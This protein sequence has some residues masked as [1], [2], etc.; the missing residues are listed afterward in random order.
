MLQNP[1]IHQTAELS[2]NRNRNEPPIPPCHLDLLSASRWSPGRLTDPPL[3]LTIRAPTQ[4]GG[5]LFGFLMGQNR[6][7]E[8]PGSPPAAPRPRLRREWPVFSIM[9]RFRHR[10]R[11]PPMRRPSRASFPGG[12]LLAFLCLFSPFAGCDRSHRDSSPDPMRQIA[13]FRAEGT[14]DQALALASQRLSHLRTQADRPAYEII[15]ADVLCRTLTDI[16]ALPLQARALMAHADSLDLPSLAELH[17]HDLPRT[18]HLLRLQARLRQQHL[19][20]DSPELA[21]SYDHLADVMWR[22]SALSSADSLYQFSLAIRRRALGADHPLV[23]STMTKLGKLCVELGDYARSEEYFRE[24]LRSRR[25]IWGD[26]SAPVAQSLTNLAG[27]LILSGDYWSAEPIA[28][29]SLAIYRGLSSAWNTESVT[30]LSNLATIYAARGDFHLA[31]PLYRQALEHDRESL[32]DLDPMLAISINNLAT[33]LQ[34]ERKYTEAEALYQEALDLRMATFGDADA[35]VA[36]SMN[37]LAN[38]LHDLGRFDQAESLY[39]RALA[40]RLDLLGPDHPDVATT[41]NNIALLDMDRGDT[42]SAEAR[43][44]E[45]IRARRLVLGRQHPRVARS[46]LQLGLLYLSE[47]RNAEAESVLAAAATAFDAARARVTPDLAR[48]TFESSPYPALAVARLRLQ[49]PVEAWAA[50]ELALGRSL[51]EILRASEQRGLSPRQSAAEDSLLKA[52]VDAEGRLEAVR[53]RTRLDRSP[54]TAHL[55][56]M[57]YGELL[58][59][60]QRWLDLEQ[61]LSRE[62][63]LTEGRR[64]D[65]DRIQNSLEPGSAV[66]GWID[67]TLGG[68]RCTQT[69][70]WGYVIRKDRGATW[71]KL[72]TSLG[73]HLSSESQPTAIAQAY[74]DVLADPAQEPYIGIP[75]ETL[76]RQV[77]TQRFAPFSALL[78]GISQLIVIPSA[79]MLGVPVEALPARPGVNLGDLVAV[80]YAPSATIYAW[81]LEKARATDGDRDKTMLLVADP[82]FDEQQRKEIETLAASPG[83]DS[84]DTM[85][86]NLAYAGPHITADRATAGSLRRLPYTRLEA[87]GIAALPGVSADLLL[88]T[89][90]REDTLRTIARD[91]RISR[92]RYVHI[93]THTIPND[94]NPE[95]SYLVLSQ[96]DLPEPIT[97]VIR[98]TPVFDGRLTARE[99]LAEWELSADLVTLS[100]CETA[101]GRSVGGEGYIGLASAFLQAGARS[102]VVSLWRVNDRSASLLMERF[103][104]NLMGASGLSGSEPMTKS[105]ALQEAKAW[106]RHYEEDGS[107][108]YEHPSHWAS[109][110][111]IGD[112]N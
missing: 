49:K 102:M 82:P 59:L 37:N 100:A 23:A 70:S 2:R 25:A 84:A 18:E 91:G 29:E 77:Y 101:L 75:A 27:L 34:D 98:G 80:S 33:V 72:P 35:R 79:S 94:R 96:V 43:F 89:A 74:R 56:D 1:T 24:S 90:A 11:T 97:A 76:A 30:S 87:Y 78:E 15:D 81:L 40:I 68:S 66:I 54:A 31:E 86:S 22:Q 105:R 67:L 99:I 109:F 73:L 58:V 39:A 38:L 112:P 28:A 64:F 32:G 95:D 10:L 36:Q 21:I 6:L 107:C 57:A 71:K 111:L 104:R 8:D 47:S 60:E 48:S 12:W 42:R 17:R 44:L 9:N 108:P 83:P 16:L 53:S 93:A 46:L 65:L 61:D 63:P 3:L 19:G 4:E 45:S 106:L 62:R 88:G 51:F 69:E 7:R 103:Y 41:L 92:Y 110:I 13:M 50:A 26:H 20:P 5:H 55:A 14:Y 52:L 85:Q